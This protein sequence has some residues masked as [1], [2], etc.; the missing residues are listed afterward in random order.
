MNK[1]DL[2]LL[3]KQ[4]MI[5]KLITSKHGPVCCA[6]SCAWPVSTQDKLVGD[7][8]RPQSYLATRHGQTNTK[9]ISQAQNNYKPPHI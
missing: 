9:G 2:L 4:Y 3:H 5:N 7:G 6:W 8:T 1:L